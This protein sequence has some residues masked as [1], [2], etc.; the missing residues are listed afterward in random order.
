MENNIGGS[1]Y[2]SIVLY[3]VPSGSF[4][5]HSSLIFACVDVL[6]NSL[7]KKNTTQW[8]NLT[9]VQT[10]G[11]LSLC[12]SGVA[13]VGDRDLPHFRSQRS[14][15]GASVPGG[16]SG[17]WVCLPGLVLCL[18]PLCLWCLALACVLYDLSCS[19]LRMCVSFEDLEGPLSAAQEVGSV[20]HFHIK[21]SFIV[22]VRIIN[23]MLAR[24]RA[25]RGKV[26]GLRQ[27]SLAG[28]SGGQLRGLPQT[29]VSV[30]SPRPRAA[31]T[32][33]SP[34]AKRMGSGS[35]QRSSDLGE[36]DLHL[37]E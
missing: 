26:T 9:T 4:Q 25:Q 5:R 12:L 2:I 27:P 20:S 21:H 7:F 30:S 6:Y 28:V 22:L 15:G 19:L 8:S 33:P 37:H 17:W 1:P 14:P 10:I 18:P 36:V 34:R 32:G 3:I 35:T 13:F 29:P 23:L 11:C 31:A 16:P 24:K